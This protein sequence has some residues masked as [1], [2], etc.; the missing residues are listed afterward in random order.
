MLVS[1]DGPFDVFAR[2]R[3]RAGLSAIPLKIDGQV[4][5]S[6]VASNTVAKGLTCVLCVSVW[7]AALFVLIKPLRIVRDILAVAAGAALL[8][9][10]IDRE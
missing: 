3:R 8:Q 4:V 10:F 5:Q 2:M 6:Q 9:R 7:T 1:E